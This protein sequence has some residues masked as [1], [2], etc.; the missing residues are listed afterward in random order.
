MREQ[1]RTCSSPSEAGVSLQHI[2]APRMGVFTSV[3][4]G[5]I[6]FSLC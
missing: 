4:E 1:V 6:L 5:E 2:R 3:A